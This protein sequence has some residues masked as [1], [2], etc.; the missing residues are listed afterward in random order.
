[1]MRHITSTIARSSAATATDD[2]EEEM[3]II[4][5][6]KAAAPL[7]LPNMER[8][9][10]HVKKPLLSIGGKGATL[11]HGNSLRQL[12]D[13]HTVVKIKINTK[14]FENSLQV[15]F[16]ALKRLAMEAGSDDI[17]LL[18]VREKENV[19]LV[20][21]QGTRALIEAGKFPPAKPVDESAEPTAV[22]K[23]NA[24]SQGVLAA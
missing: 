1:M 4:P 5:T 20:G 16:E 12:L 6:T 23:G 24:T 22:S 17:E 2:D 13:A 9:W 10:R 18:Q 21:A 11:S 15:A 14:Q 8:A 19:I 3:I 7:L